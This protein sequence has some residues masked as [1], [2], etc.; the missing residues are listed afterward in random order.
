[1]EAATRLPDRVT[2][3]PAWDE[4]APTELLTPRERD[5]LRLI[6]TGATNNEIAAQLSVSEGTVKGHVSSLQS[7]LG[8]RDRT[9][10]TVYAR[11]R[12]L[13]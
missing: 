7:R 13:G 10:A 5:V 12:G 1:M 11:D 9:R 4:T 2:P 8:L 6:A 3:T